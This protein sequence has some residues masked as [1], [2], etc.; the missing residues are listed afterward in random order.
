[1]R[2]SRDSKLKNIIK[3]TKPCSSKIKGKTGT[4]I[5]SYGMSISRIHGWGASS[6]G[7]ILWYTK[8]KKGE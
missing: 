3:G 1:M 8:Y 5:K 6:L 4:N 7:R 2:H